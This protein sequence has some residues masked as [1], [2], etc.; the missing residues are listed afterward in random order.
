VRG[1]ASRLAAG[2]GLATVLVAG[3]L[4]VGSAA[5]GLVAVGSV[6]APAGPAGATTSG[7]DH[8]ECAANRAVGPITYV[9]PFGFDASGG[10]I[11]VFAAQKLGFFRQMC[12][13][14]TVDAAAQDGDELV[15]AGRAQVTNIGGAA[16][17]LEVVANGSN[18]VGVATLADTTDEAVVTPKSVTSLR[19]LEGQTLGYHTAVGVAVQAMMAK[20][21]VDVTK[22][23][24]VSTTN[25]TPDQVVN[26][27]VDGLQVYQSNEPLTLRSQGKSFNEFTPAEFGVKGTYNVQAF[28]GTFLR[29]HRQAAADWMRADLHAVDY[30]I[31]HVT[32]CVAIEHAV[33]AADHATTAFPVAHE[34]Q[35]WTFES[36]LIS[37]HT[38]AGRGIGVQT[39]AEWA[40]EA[41]QLASFGVV[42]DVP[43]LA[44][45][46]DT[47][48]TAGL[49]RGKTLIWP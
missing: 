20:A 9:S 22:V 24:L 39:T 29:E 4:A 45:A 10:I 34:E 33:A 17:L 42:K 1:R 23:D 12:L 3:A 44:K 27:T 46:E 7:L 31:A 35:V 5:V 13:T 19:G 18:L 41:A 28:N 49:Y 21:G 16:T 47:T 26:G 32:R 48:L 37:G 40:P 14:V 38:L 11:D 30:C 6:V 8:A 15:S 2:T 43:P 25:Y 36:H